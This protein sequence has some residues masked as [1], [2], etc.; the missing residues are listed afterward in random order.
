MSYAPPPKAHQWHG[1]SMK[2]PML[3]LLAVAVAGCAAPDGPVPLQTQPE[4]LVCLAARVSGVLVADAT[5]GLAYKNGGNVQGVVWPH[6]YSARRE[7]GVVVLIDPTGR[8][9]AREGDHIVSAG[10]YDTNDIARPCGD[11]EVNPPTQ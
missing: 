3:M 6:G 1:M 11:L 7:S 5:Y 8:I 2:S 9:V 10:D 4:A